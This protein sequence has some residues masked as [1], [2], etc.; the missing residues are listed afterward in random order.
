MLEIELQREVSFAFGQNAPQA[1]AEISSHAITK[2]SNNPNLTADE[3]LAEAKKVGRRW[4]LSCSPTQ[5]SCCP[6]DRHC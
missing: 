2:I 3:K 4:S 5:C 1:V 6:S